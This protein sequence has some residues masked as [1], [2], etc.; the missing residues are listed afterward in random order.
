MNRCRTAFLIGWAGFALACGSSEATTAGDT[1]EVT[2][3]VAEATEVSSDVAAEPG[4]VAPGDAADAEATGD[5]P[6]EAATAKCLDQVD[7]TLT[8]ALAGLGQGVEFVRD[9]WGIPHLYARTTEDLFEAQGFVTGMDRIIQMQGMRLITRGTY[10]NTVLAGPSDLTSDVYMRVLDLRGTAQKMWADIQANEPSLK[11]VLEA[12]A[13]GVNAYIDATKAGLTDKPLEW[14]ILGQWDPWTPVDSLTIGRLQSWDLSFSQYTDE[15]SMSRNLQAMGAQIADPA[16]RKALAADAYRSA[17][18]AGATILPPVSG[19][20]ALHAPAPNAAALRTPAGPKT[21]AFPAGYF[22]HVWKGL[23]Q[24]SARPDLLKMGGGSNNWAVAG[25]LTL[26]GNAILAND[27]H[28]ALRNPPVFYII[29]MD[30]A[31]AGGDLAL[32]GVS[33]PGIP[34]II[35]G[36]NAKAAWAGTVHPYDVTDVYIETLTDGTPP[37]AAFNGGQVPLTIRQESFTYKKPTA[38]CGAFLEDFVTGLPYK[39]TEDATTCTL[40][41]DI[42]VVPHHGP[43][44]P[45]SKTTAGD[46]IIAL[47]WRWTGFEPTKELKAEEIEKLLWLANKIQPS[48]KAA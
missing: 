10:A 38:G 36:H 2:T 29:H 7:A 19:A 48:E 33:F 9:K 5:V 17:P 22:E 30:T 15:V 44:I 45:G 20:L 28:L 27:P 26:S 4:E 6:V 42:W 39:V 3:D 46:K 1:T 40:V 23:Q 18:A 13:R 8:F 24:G 47:S 35:L 14:D 43:I 12:Y 41:A 32:S 25:K 34:G 31:R 21:P 16:Y 37:T 11:A